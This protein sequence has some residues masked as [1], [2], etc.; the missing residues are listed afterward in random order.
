[1][2][3]FSYSSTCWHMLFTWVKEVGMNLTTLSLTYSSPRSTSC[4]KELA[5]DIK[6]S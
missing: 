5:T 6:A 3:L 1:M 2:N 4:K